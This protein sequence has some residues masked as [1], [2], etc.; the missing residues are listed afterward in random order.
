MSSFCV[1]LQ[2]YLGFFMNLY[3]SGFSLSV[4]PGSLIAGILLRMSVH[5]FT[6]LEKQ[7][8]NYVRVVRS[9]N[10][11]SEVSPSLHLFLSGSRLCFL[12]LATRVP[13]GSGMVWSVLIAFL[14]VFVRV[15][16]YSD[17]GQPLPRSCVT[18]RTIAQ[19]AGR[20]L[21]RRRRVRCACRAVIS[22]T[23]KSVVCAFTIGLHLPW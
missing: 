13:G 18:A 19:S 1:L 5:R 7:R 15:Y 16:V 3:S 4:S 14:C 6:K 8:R 12:F 17:A 23:C 11:R 21:S 2:A 20:N 22:F 10:E 9:L